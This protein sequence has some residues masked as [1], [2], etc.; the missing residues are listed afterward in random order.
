MD[1]KM[2]NRELRGIREH[3]REHCHFIYTDYSEYQR[4]EKLAIEDIICTLSHLTGIDLSKDLIT[5]TTKLFINIS[6]TK[7]ILSL[8]ID[9]VKIIIKKVL[10]KLKQ[11]IRQNKIDRQKITKLVLA[12]QKWQNILNIVNKIPE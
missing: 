2:F 5:L 7:Y 8:S 1:R 9:D 10:R 6:I 4:R 11:M 3:F 12:A